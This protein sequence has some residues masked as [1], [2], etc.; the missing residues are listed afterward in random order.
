[1]AELYKITS[2]GVIM[3][4]KKSPFSDEPKDLEDF[5]MKNEKILGDVALLNHQITLSGNKRI[6]IWGVDL[7]DWRP[8][9][10]ELKNEVCGLEIIP[11]ILPY[12]NF[13]KTNP[14]TL[15]FNALSNT[16]FMKKLQEL[17]VDKEKLSK[18]LEGDPKVILVAPGFK[19]ELLD[20]TGF[21]KFD[22]EVIQISR[23]ESEEKEFLVAI[24][25]PQI[26]LSPPATVR[27][28][29]DWDWEKYEREGISAKKIGIAKNIKEQ[30]DQLIKIEEIDLK[31]IFRKFYIPYQIGRNNVF[32]IDIGYTSWETGDV[33][34][35]FKLEKNV[36]LKK[37]G[38]MIEHTKTEWNEGYDNWTIYFNTK[39]NITPLLPIIK[40][41]YEYVTG[42]KIE[43]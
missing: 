2:A 27:V 17:G 7:L 32:L 21:I 20:T 25:K 14:D 26:A 33:Y 28:M 35:S 16:R 10:V 22:I 40:R 4:I 24:D 29:E 41:S 8:I 5:I 37:E 12:Y 6:D 42:V 39:V 36:D 15:K 31:P 23:Y 30:I 43:D 1:M 13:V 18:G 11:Q 3:E 34:I 19:D 9:I 38:I